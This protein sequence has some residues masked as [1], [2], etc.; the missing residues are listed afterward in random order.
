[1]D[2]NK[3][4]DKH[5]SIIMPAYNSEST[6]LQAVESV[7]NQSYPYWELIIIEDG[8]NDDT[9]RIVEE[10]G[11]RDP[12]IQAIFNERNMGVSCSRNC[13][14]SA[15]QGEWIAF[16]DSDDLWDSSKLSKQIHLVEELGA[17]FVFTGSAYMDQNGSPYPGIFNVPSQLTYQFL[18][19]Q[20]VIPCSSVLLSKE[21][22]YSNK[23]ENDQMHEDYAVWLKILKTG[24]V[25][26]GID[27]P[28]IAYRLSA[29]SKSGNKIKSIKMNYRVHQYLGTK[30]IES[31][32]YTGHHILRGL[33][34]YA[35][36][37][38]GM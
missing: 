20:N 36:I 34:K 19:L 21:L 27:E 13:G 11:S 37:Y 24:V 1:M 14:L 12:R 15:V 9:K 23:M 4:Y 29:N 31:L 22:M 2:V 26:Y 18:R 35:K 30:R 7:I 17:E 6:I 16:L 3:I 5:V 10:L 8:S 32:Y 38:W 33:R 25:A 28:L